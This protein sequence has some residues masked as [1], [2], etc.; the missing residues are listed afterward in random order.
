M[1][2]KHTVVVSLDPETEAIV[3][4]LGGNRSQW[5]REA[6]K[7]RHAND[8]EI[9]VALAEA[10]QR[11]VNTAARHMRYLVQSLRNFEMENDLTLNT[12]DCIKECE[13][14]LELR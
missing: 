7:W 3:K 9:M 5:I 12:L 11:Q 10:R 2:S 6:V 13:D 1:P 8:Y 14:W 4:A